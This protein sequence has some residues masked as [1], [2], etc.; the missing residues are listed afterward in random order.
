MAKKKEKTL[1]EKIKIGFNKMLIGSIILNILFLL[2]GII[3]YSNPRVSLELLGIFLGVY[4]IIFGLYEIFEF[5]ARDNNPLYGLNILWG[6][7]AI[8]VGLLAII[9]P[10]G[11]S[12][13]LTFTLGIY[14]IIISISKIID[15]FKLRKYKYDGWALI[16]VISI[17]LLIFGIFIIINPII[18]AMEITEVTGIFI[19]LASILEICNSIMLYS[20]A[21]DVLELFKK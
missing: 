6:I 8:I 14:L 2:F 1:F 17:I 4:F 19:I 9:N 12:T 11:I 10:F 16:L 7:L 20:K 18:S 15:A 5:I 3:V 13:I 21:K